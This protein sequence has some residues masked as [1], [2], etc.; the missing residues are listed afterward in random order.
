[1]TRSRNGIILAALLAL[2]GQVS[3]LAAD[4]NSSPDFQEVYDLIHQHAAGMSAVE[5][6]RAA[7]QGLVMA[8]GPRVAL[9]T[10]DPAA[11][12]AIDKKPLAETILFDGDI[13]YFRIARVSR[14]T[15][16]SRQ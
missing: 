12:F 9:G 14:W 6:N 8:L 16:E 13:A 3:A 5:L 1:M 15:G 10:N 4:T 7:V 2:A 11:N